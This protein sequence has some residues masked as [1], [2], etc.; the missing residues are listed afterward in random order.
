MDTICRFKFLKHMLTN[1]L[2]TAVGI[3]RVL[4]M[5]FIN[6]CINRFPKSGCGGRK[7]DIF[8]ACFYHS[9]QQVQHIGYIIV[10]ITGWSCNRVRHGSKCSEMND[11]INFF[12]C[13]N[14]FY[15]V[16][17]AKASL[18]E[19]PEYD[20]FFMTIAQIIEYNC[21]NSFVME[22]SITMTSNISCTASN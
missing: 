10:I 18:D 14:L 20:G 3:N 7:Y 12:L 2:C 9:I 1:K 19:F 17:I 6:R 11:C 21:M 22:I 16:F 15:Q 8:Y 4:R 13:Q 5:F